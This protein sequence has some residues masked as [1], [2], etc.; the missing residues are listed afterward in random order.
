MSQDNASPPPPASMQSISKQPAMWMAPSLAAVAGFVDTTGF[1]MFAGLFLAHVTGNFVVLGATLSGQ[2][3]GSTLLKVAVLP[4]F[5]SGVVIGWVILRIS[6]RRGSR[7]L[8]ATEALLLLTCGVGGVLGARGL[9]N[10]SVSEICSV[11]CGVLAMGVQ[12]M[13]SRSL[14]LPMTH[15]MTGN[16]TQLTVDVLDTR[17]NH[18]DSSSSAKK[19]SALVMAFA[20]GAGS[21]GLIVPYLGLAALLIPAILLL[22][23]AVAIE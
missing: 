11:A 12:S 3:R 5:I 6:A 2:D 1:I 20:T 21:A 13:L 18:A 14:K 7:R 15:V 10:P 16:V 22:V 9:L 23:L 19:N 4:L 8:A 17:F